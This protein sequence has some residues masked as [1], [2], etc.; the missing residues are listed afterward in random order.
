MVARW[1]CSGANTTRRGPVKGPGLPIPSGTNPR[2]PVSC[3]L[4]REWRILCQAI[5]DVIFAGRRAG[6]S[7][8][9]S[10]F[11]PNWSNRFAGS[12]DTFR[13]GF[14]TEIANGFPR[15]VG[16]GGRGP[17][18]VTPTAPS[19]VPRSGHGLCPSIVRLPSRTSV[20]RIRSDGSGT[21]RRGH[22]GTA[23]LARTGAADRMCRHGVAPTTR[24]GIR[25]CPARD[26]PT[27]RRYECDQADLCEHDPS[28]I[29]PPPVRHRSGGRYGW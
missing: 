2:W 21:G 3:A 15:R 9:V 20:P 10:A 13:S 26:S 19:V 28:S 22:P 16:G 24:S 5:D 4:T 17:L 23:R 12:L 7:L 29:R 1:W 8:A 27:R 18:S 14:H 11:S 6:A 25:S